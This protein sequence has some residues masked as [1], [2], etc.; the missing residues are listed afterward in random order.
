MGDWLGIILGLIGMFM[1]LAA[2]FGLK[3]RDDGTGRY[4]FTWWG[5]V[6]FATACVFIALLMLVFYT[7]R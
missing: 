1:L 3:R 7:T 5:W 6:F 4:R 2:S